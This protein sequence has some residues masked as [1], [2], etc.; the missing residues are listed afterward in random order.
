[1]DPVVALLVTAAI[2][3]VGYDIV[4]DALPILVDQSARAPQ[5]IREAALSVTGVQ[6]A[7]A[8]RSR[9]TAGAAVAELTIRVAGSMPV[10][11]AHDIAD[12]VEARL[13]DALGLEEVLVHVEPC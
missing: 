5:A 10:G 4:K 9:S 2:A 3:H 1:V 13:K 6:S 11:A 12:A 8:I 7:M